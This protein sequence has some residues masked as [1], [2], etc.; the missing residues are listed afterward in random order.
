MGLTYANIQLQN[1]ADVE[2]FRRGKMDEA[3]I[4]QIDIKVLVN[5]KSVIPTIN[6]SIRA[7]LDLPIIGKR[8][9]QIYDGGTT[10]LP[11]VGPIRVKYLDRW[12]IT[13]AL[14]L[15]DDQEALLGAIPLEEMDL[16]IHPARNELL[17]VH[18]EGPVMSLK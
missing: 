3:E 14:L 13:S 1:N 17:V 10:E 12:C 18:P 16:Y 15:P 2:F 5:K 6:E 8:R 4:R 7:A 9:S 11:V